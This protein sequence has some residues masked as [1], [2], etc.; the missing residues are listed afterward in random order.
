MFIFSY[1]IR[2]IDIFVLNSPASP[3]SIIL[4]KTLPLLVLFYVVMRIEK[5][6]LE[7]IGL[8]GKQMAGNFFLGAIL[9]FFTLGY[10]YVPDMILN[11]FYNTPLNKLQFLFDWGVAY[12]LFF[13]LVNGFMEE[14]VF[15]GYLQKKFYVVGKWNAI[16]IQ[17]FLFGTWHVAWTFYNFYNFFSHSWMVNA[18]YATEYT[19]GYVFFTFIFGIIMGYA[20]LKTGSLWGPV[21][22]H[23]FYNFI[24]NFFMPNAGAVAELIRFLGYPVMAAVCLLVVKFVTEK[25]KMEEEENAPNPSS[26]AL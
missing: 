15:R 8:S 6:G 18:S 16:F 25:M 5:V 17:A 4:S 10:N 26:T 23:T 3:R 9:L 22:C 2:I 14:G 11:I 21:F 13:C 12:Y 7:Y 24:Q 1:V 20:F 19:I